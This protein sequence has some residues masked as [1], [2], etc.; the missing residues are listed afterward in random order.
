MGAG[1]QGE[2]EI[3]TFSI[4]DVNGAG[5]DISAGLKGRKITG[6]QNGDDGDEGEEGDHNNDNGWSNSGNADADAGDW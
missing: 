6:G 5:T 1:L 4:D 3:G 2:F